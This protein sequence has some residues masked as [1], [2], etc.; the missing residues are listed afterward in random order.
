MFKTDACRAPLSPS[1]RGSVT[2][3]TALAI[4]ILLAVAVIGVW[5]ISVGIGALRVHDAARAAA[6]AIAH[7]ESLDDA[8]EL[9]HRSAPDATI[10]IETNDE[11][12]EV[13]ARERVKSSLPIL[14]AVGITIERTVVAAREE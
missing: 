3:E 12:V 13:R 8:R 5:C 2:L 10:V 11:T 9:A 6:R 1:E 14:N 4:P 7:G